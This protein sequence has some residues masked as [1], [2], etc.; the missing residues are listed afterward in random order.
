[1]KPYIEIPYLFVAKSNRRGRPIYLGQLSISSQDSRV[2]FSNNFSFQNYGESGPKTG[3]LRNTHTA[4]QLVAFAATLPMGRLAK[5]E[6]LAQAALF[7]ASDES[8]FMTGSMLA[9]D[10]GQTA[11]E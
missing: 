10:G 8:S 1:M 9:I 6:E 5:P 2:S 4:D 3:L 7:C 11:Q